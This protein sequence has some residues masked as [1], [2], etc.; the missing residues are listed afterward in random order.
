[1]ALGARRECLPGNQGDLMGQAMLRVNYAVDSALG[2]HISA[3]VEVRH[4]GCAPEKR[5]LSFRESRLK[6]IDARARDGVGTLSRAAE[7]LGAMVS[8]EGELILV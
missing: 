7:V 3:L 5:G 4:A 6:V 8:V 2:N 1:M